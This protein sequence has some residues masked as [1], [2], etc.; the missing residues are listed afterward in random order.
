MNRTRTKP[1]QIVFTRSIYRIETE[2]EKYIF[3]VGEID[4][5]T[6]KINYQHLI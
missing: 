2:N 1:N 6:V 5:N 4:T 3:T